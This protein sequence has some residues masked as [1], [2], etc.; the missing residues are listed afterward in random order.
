MS[1][2][3]DMEI[4]SSVMKGEIHIDPF[5]SEHD[6]QLLMIYAWVIKAMSAG[7]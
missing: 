2:M 3:R 7:S 4:I 6:K 5:V 1:I